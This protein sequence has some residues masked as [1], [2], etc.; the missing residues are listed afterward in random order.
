MKLLIVICVLL[1]PYLIFA[2]EKSIVVLITS[3]NNGRWVDKNVLSALQQDYTH[4]R[5]IYIDD[6][7]T[8]GT[9]RRVEDLVRLHKNKNN[10]TLI[11]NAKRKGA[12]ANIHYAVHNLCENDA[13]IVSLDGDDWFFDN[14]VLKKINAIYNENEI[15]ITHGTLIEYPSGSTDWNL[16]IPPDIVSCNQFRSYRCPSHLRTF[17]SWLFKKIR[18]E[19]LLYEGEFFPMAWDQAIMFPMM[20]M[21]AE[22]HCFIPNVLY[23]YNMA[24][25]LNDNKVD[26]ALQRNLEAFIRAKLPYQRLEDKN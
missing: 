11:R 23:V 6:E 19:D 1:F 26:P 8:D 7:S 4:Y 3:Y 10:F 14:Q 21:A 5:V 13:I 12:L 22:R 18:L 20:E 24:N 17:Y 15:W 16:Q 2:E 9:V 25:P